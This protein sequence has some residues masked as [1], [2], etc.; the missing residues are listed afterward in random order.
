[1]RDPTVT[2]GVPPIDPHE[3]GVNNAA[4]ADKRT[5]PHAD[6]KKGERRAN[7]DLARRCDRLLGYGGKLIELWAAVEA[8][9]EAS[10]GRRSA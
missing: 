3:V 5:G 10:V 2:D 4:H 6:W 1:M 7:S 8:R 9:S